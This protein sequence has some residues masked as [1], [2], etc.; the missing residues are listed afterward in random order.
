MER[1]S[2][3]GMQERRDARKGGGS[4]AKEKCRKVGIHE[5]RDANLVLKW[6]K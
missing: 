6:C 4:E 2:K 5:M 1:C 3:G